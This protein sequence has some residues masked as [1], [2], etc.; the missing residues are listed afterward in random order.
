MSDTIL[1]DLVQADRVRIRLLGS[2]P[3]W[4]EAADV[5]REIIAVLKTTW[6]RDRYLEPGAAHRL[7]AIQACD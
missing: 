4:A 2:G 6:T 1:E 5:R 7:R 3:S